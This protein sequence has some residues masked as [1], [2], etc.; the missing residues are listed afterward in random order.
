VLVETQQDL[1]ATPMP[2]EQTGQALPPGNE[3]D[4]ENRV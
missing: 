1:R 3:R 4:L 2:F